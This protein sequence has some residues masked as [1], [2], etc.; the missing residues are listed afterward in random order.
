MT[1]ALTLS[2]M[3][4]VFWRPQEWLIPGLFGWPLL[5]VITFVALLSLLLEAQSKRVRFPRSVAAPLVLG[6]WIATLV[7]HVP[8]TYF[9][10]LLATF[11]E[12]FKICFFLVLLLVAIDTPSRLRIVLGMIVCLCCIMA[13]HAV[14]QQRNGVGFAG[15]TPLM[16]FTPEKGWYSRS[17]FFGIFG[18]PNDLAQILA[19]AIPLVFAIPRRLSAAPLGVCAL[20]A[21][22]LFYAVLTTHSRGGQIA[23]LTACGLMVLMMLPARAMIILIPLGLIGFLVLCGTGGLIAMDESARDRIAFWGQANRAFKSNP[24]FGL[25]HGMFWQVAGDRAAHN[26]FVSCYTEIGIFG[27]WFWFS[28]LQS[29]VFGCWR[30]R[31]FLGSETKGDAAYLR[32]AAGLAIASMGGF[33]AAAYFLSRAFVFPLFFLLAIVHA[34]PVL[35]QERLPAGHPPLILWRRDVLGWGTVS[36][37]ASVM[38]IY[39]SIL[40]LNR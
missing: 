36:T 25:G 9:E 6:L 12:T 27:Y 7:S 21:G 39:I 3:I 4:L 23:L 32:R 29:G 34:I 35:V 33:A 14:L 28:L 31:L 22:F 37:L 19:A 40:L 16:V 20:F 1:F 11:P 8:H 24:V 17:L 15:Q 2:F 38:Y 5:D 10:G 13:V 18:D 26:A 30:V